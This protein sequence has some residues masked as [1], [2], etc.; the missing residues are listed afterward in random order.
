MCCTCGLPACKQFGLGRPLGQRRH[1]AGACLAQL[2]TSQNQPAPSPGSTVDQP[3]P[4]LLPCAAN[5]L[6]QETVEH[7]A[8]GAISGVQGSLQSL[9]QVP[10]HEVFVCSMQQGWSAQFR[11]RCRGLWPCVV[12]TLH[13]HDT[14][15]AQPR[16]NT[17]MQACG[18]HLTLRI[19][20][21]AP[22]A[23]AGIRGR[24][25]CPCHRELC[26]ADGRL[27]LRGVCRSGAVH[28]ICAAGTLWS[29]HAR[30]AAACVTD[31]LG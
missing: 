28:S 25:A 14:L 12:N 29:R 6:I 5:Q 27:V 10:G 20:A 15:N 17:G 24:R 30:C 16:G 31:A 13:A 9:F 1:R 19:P 26:M 18:F 23:D 2:L 22:T 8:L 3:A 21:V 4:L 11:A 7:S